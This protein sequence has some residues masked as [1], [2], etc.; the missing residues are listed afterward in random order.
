MSNKKYPFDPLLKHRIFI[1]LGLAVWVFLFLYFTKPLDVNELGSQ[2]QPIYLPLYGI[3]A[4][5]SYLATLPFQSWLF[6]RS[7]QRWTSLNELLYFGLILVLGFIITRSVY[8]YIVME[9]HPNS[10][11]VGYFAQAIYLPGIVTIFPIIAIGRWSFGKYK[12]KKLEDQKIEIEGA[13]NYEN[14]RLSL[15]DLICIQSSDNYIEITYKEE[16][17]F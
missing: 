1:A 13:G 17:E 14:F 6:K 4:A 3:F 10:Y 2:E 15:N 12:D 9:Q 5:L 7:N 11:S 16:G 8:F